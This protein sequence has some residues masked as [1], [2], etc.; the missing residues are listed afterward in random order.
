MSILYRI[1]NDYNLIYRSNDK[2]GVSLSLGSKN[3][4]IGE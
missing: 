4:F 3:K 2:C 1:G